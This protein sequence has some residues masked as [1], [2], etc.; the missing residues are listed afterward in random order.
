MIWLHTQGGIAEVEQIY[1]FIFSQL[2][3][4]YL[5]FIC[6]FVLGLGA[7]EVYLP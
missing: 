1:Q 5:G 7:Y 6:L 4:S 3:L 2:S